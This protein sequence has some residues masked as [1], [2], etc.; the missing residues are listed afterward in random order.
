MLTEVE[1]IERWDLTYLGIVPE[2]RRQGLGG[3]SSARRSTSP[4]SAAASGSRI[5]VDARNLPACQLVPECG[6]QL[7]EHRLVSLAFL[8]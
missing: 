8:S 2:R 7:V 4:T 6:F 1:P 5:A 3:P